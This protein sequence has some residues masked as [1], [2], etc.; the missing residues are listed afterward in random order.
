[1]ADQSGWWMYHGDTAHTGNAGGSE[2]NSLNVGRLEILYSLELSGPLLSVPAVVD[3]HIYCGLANTLDAPD[4]NGGRFLKIDLAT[5][6]IVRDFR[7]S[8]KIGE[9]DSHGFMGM[10]CTPAVTGTRIY[11]MAL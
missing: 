8:T 5:G 7:W 6:S 11:F 1:M 9:G 4:A 10:A 2:I 3:G